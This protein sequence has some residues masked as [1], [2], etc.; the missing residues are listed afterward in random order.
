VNKL[1]YFLNVVAVTAL[2]FSYLSPWVSPGT[3]WFFSIFALIFGLNPISRTFQLNLGSRSGKEDINIVSYNIRSAQLFVGK[4]KD[5][6]LA[7]FKKFISKDDAD[8]YCFQEQGA[9]AM[10]KFKHVFNDFHVSNKLGR[11]TAIYS[12]F[13]LIAEGNIKLESD[14]HN[15]SWADMIAHGDTIRLYCVHLSSNRISNTTDQLKEEHDLGERETWSNVKY[16]LKKYAIHSRKRLDQIQLVIDHIN[17]SPYPVVI[18]GDLN[19]V[20]QSYIYSKI[21]KGRKD[22]FV[23]AGNGLGTSYKDNLPGLRID[24]VFTDP[25][26][27]IKRH[28]LLNKPF[29]D[30]NPIKSIIS[31]DN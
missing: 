8:I 5:Q 11:G 9:R 13:P 27:H 20:P 31:L 17:K 24:Y 1:L 29:S 23:E 4:D 3:T 25:E 26:F 16:V 21:S 7:S 19:D 2:L 12:K 28:K 14:S 15:A 18:C 10:K 6:E 22:S 30:H